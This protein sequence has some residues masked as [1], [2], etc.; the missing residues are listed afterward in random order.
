MLVNLCLAHF[1]TSLNLNYN[2][3][4]STIFDIVT[5]I[6]EALV[7][8]LLDNHID[9]FNKMID[10]NL[11]LTREELQPRYA[12]SKNRYEKFRG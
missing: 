10:L 7:V 11:K 9:S 5:V 4:D 12:N 1:T 3:Y 8:L 6:Y 2:T